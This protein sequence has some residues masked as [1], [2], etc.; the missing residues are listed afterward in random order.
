[1]Y[2]DNQMISFFQR[3]FWLMIE[4]TIAIHHLLE[5]QMYHTIVRH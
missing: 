4:Y 5:I 1:M 2:T 3:I